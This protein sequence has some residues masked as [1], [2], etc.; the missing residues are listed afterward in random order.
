MPHAGATSR[1]PS[2]LA[3]RVKDRSTTYTLS[4]ASDIVEPLLALFAS[5]CPS[6]EQITAA[7]GIRRFE[8]LVDDLIVVGCARDPEAA[9][10]AIAAIPELEGVHGRTKRRVVVTYQNADVVVRI[11]APDEFGTMLHSSTGSREHLSAVGARRARGRLCATR[12]G[13]LRGRRASLDSAGAATRHGRSRSCGVS[14]VAVARRTAADPRRSPHALDVQR[15]PGLAGGDGRRLER[16][17]LRVHRDHRSLGARGRGADRLARRSRPS[18]RR[19]RA[20]A[21]TL[22]DDHHP[23]RHR[24]GHHA[25]RPARLPGFHP[26]NARHRARVAARRR[27]SERACADAPL[28]RRDPASARLDHHA[29]RQSDR[30]TARTLSARL[31]RHLRGRRRKRDSARNRRRAAPP[32][33]G[34]R[35]RARGRRCWRHGVDRQRLSP[36]SA[37][38]PATCG[39][40]SAPPGAA[41]SSRSTC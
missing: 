21:R 7:G 16:A 26:R 10:D 36:G 17:R 40:G 6:L 34:R 9:I 37:R 38:L 18:A 39:S 14:N 13:R 1:R 24:S 19:D 29:P 20:A 25:G 22:S 33:P 28:H 27:G 3:H 41:G 30:R 8:P 23:P 32:G 2:G 12:G 11:A 5:S 35:T 4:R 31:R 15:W